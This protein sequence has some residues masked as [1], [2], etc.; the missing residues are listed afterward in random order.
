M[1]PEIPRSVGAEH[2]FLFG[3]TAEEVLAGHRGGCI[4]RSVVAKQRARLDSDLRVIF[5]LANVV[6]GSS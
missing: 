2:F 3:P 4:A 1:P 5:G 6:C